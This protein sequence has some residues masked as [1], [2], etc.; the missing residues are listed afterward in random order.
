[1]PDQYKT[2]TK[3]DTIAA[4]ST[5]GTVKS[6]PSLSQLLQAHKIVAD[7]ISAA[8]RDPLV[9]K[10]RATAEALRW[11][12]SSARATSWEEFGQK[13]QLLVDN[14]T[15]GTGEDWLTAIQ[16]GIYWDLQQLNGERAAAERSAVALQAAE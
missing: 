3:T 4:L 2:C 11:D 6:A 12:I 5:T 13:V 14:T 15:E 9:E 16:E 10:Y 7:M 1:M 8:T